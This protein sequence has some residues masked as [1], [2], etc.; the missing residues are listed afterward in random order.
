MSKQKRTADPI[1]AKMR[2]SQTTYALRGSDFGKLRE[3]GVPPPVLDYM[4][5][6]FVDDVDGVEQLLL[7]PNPTSDDLTLR[8]T[9]GMQ[10]KVLSI[11][12]HDT[13]GRLRQVLVPPASGGS[14]TLLVLPV[15]GLP[16]GVYFLTVRGAEGTWTGRF[17]KLQ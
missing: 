8:F 5:Q 15:S 12:I 4:Q 1:I 14:S 11:E 9:P 10:E 2:T 7:Y 17:V 13:A 16:D 6:S 3:V